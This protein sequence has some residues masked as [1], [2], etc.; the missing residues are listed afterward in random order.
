MSSHPKERSNLSAYALFAGVL[1]AA[2]LPIYMHAPKFFFDQYG[3]GLGAL[4]AVLFGLRLLDVVQDPALG[5][6]SGRVKRRATLIA[7]V[8]ST[9]AAAMLGVFAL[10][11]PVP[12]LV[13]FAFSLGVLSTA[14]SF[15]S[16]TFYAQGIA[17][18]ERSP[19]VSHVRLATWRETGALI[20]ICVAAVAP[21]LLALLTPKPFALFSV[22]FVVALGFAILS[23]RR[24]WLVVSTDARPAI[25]V[26]LRDSG[27]RRLLLIAF[28]NSAP[29]AVTSTLFLFFVQYRLDAPGLEGPLLLLFFVAAA[30]SAPLWGKAGRFYGLRRTLLSG[31]ILAVVTFG[32]AI[33]LGSG[34]VLAFAV[35]CVASGA[36]LGADMTLLPAAFSVHVASGKNNAGQAFG[37]WN[38][39]SKANLALAAVI[40]LPVLD[41]AGLSADQPVGPGGLRTLTLL[42]AVLPCVMKLIAIKLLMTS[43]V[44]EKIDASARE[45]LPT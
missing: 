27:T 1:S 29:V 4:G 43:S 36:A 20:G 21:T 40:V 37:L 23:M 12:P 44:L 18:V 26:L 22:L 13:W 34:D 30:I 9:M 19:D 11:P 17:K 38:F 35:I 33:S 10:A 16:I 8:G 42:Y 5:W 7:V 3:V 25:A 24:E 41:Y 14:F 39:V 15:L 2:G 28:V 6:F 32:F 45:A 31:M